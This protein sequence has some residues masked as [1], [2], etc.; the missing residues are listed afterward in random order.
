LGGYY[1]PISGLGDDIDGLND[2]KDYS[3]PPTRDDPLFSDVPSDRDMAGA[4][5]WTG[6]GR[7]GTATPSQVRFDIE[8]LIAHQPTP[9]LWFEGFGVIAIVALID[10]MTGAYLSLSIFY[11][12]PVIFTAWFLSRRVGMLAAVVSV[13]AWNYPTLMHLT[14]TLWVWGWNTTVRL[15]FFLVVLQLVHLM[16]VAKYREASLARTDP[17]TG[18]ANGRSFNDRAEFELATLRRTGHPLT[19]AYVDLDRFKHINDTL[20]HTEGDRL[21]RAAANAIQS[22]LRATD[23]V[24]RLGGDEFGVMLPDTDRDSAPAVLEAIREAVREVVD[25]AW[26]AGCTIGALT[27]EMAPESVDFMVRNADEL[28]YRG[29]RAGRGRIEHAVW[30]TRHAE[31]VKTDTPPTC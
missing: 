4:R 18:V 28:M 27:F 21:L 17:L 9:F 19:M 30:P 8:A 5:P 22:R 25:G 11:L 7:S 20:G 1:E 29:K 2:I 3:G 6:W 31:S 26:E 15:M 12:I 14:T 24:A 23:L 16:R 10:A 13:A